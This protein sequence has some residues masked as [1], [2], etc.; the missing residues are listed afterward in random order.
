MR[1]ILVSLFLCLIATPAFSQIDVDRVMRIGCNTLYFDDYVLSIRYFNQAIEAKPWLAQPY[2]YR[3]I[4][5]LNLDDYA[6][7]ELDATY[8]I[9]RNPFLYDA[10]EVR[11][12][13][14]QNSGKLK[15]A[16]ED[17]NKVLESLPESRALLFNKAMAQIDL[18]QY[19][20]ADSTFT[21][22]LRHHPS[23]DGGWIG[24]ARMRLERTDTVGA[25][26]DINKALQCNPNNA[27]AYVMRADIAINR[28]ARP[29][30]ALADMDKAIKLQPRVAGYFI[31]R[32]WLRYKADDYYGAMA[33]YDYA[34]R[35]EPTNTIALFNRS[36]LRY[37]VH[38][39]NKAVDDLTQV[40]RLEPNNHKALFNRAVLY[41]ET[42]QFREAIADLDKLIEIFPDFSAAWFLR[43]EVKN[44]MGRKDAKAD[45]NRSMALASKDVDLKAEDFFGG[46][47]ADKESEA[48]TQDQVKERF[49]TLQ[50]L[51]DA[52]APEDEVYNNPN[53]K[54]RIQD[55]RLQTSLLPPYR[56]TYYLAAT[57]MRPS[58]LWLKEIQEINDSRQ[59]PFRLLASTAESSMASDEET[60]TAHNNSVEKFSARLARG[61]SP[62]AI[63]YFGRGMDF[64][65]LRDFPAAIA[66]FTEAINIAPDFAL[67]YFARANA[68]YFD[69]MANSKQ[70][71]AD[72][73]QP[74]L[75]MITAQ[76]VADLDKAAELSP[77]MAI[78]H[79]NKGVALADL[80][81]DNT[82]A[83]AAF[84]RAIEIDP[85]LAEAWYNRGYVFLSL[86]SWNE[87]SA[88]LSR[89][90]ELGIPASYSLLKQMGR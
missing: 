89:A 52:S 42:G 33:D 88:D 27:N 28:D 49:T 87:A 47:T 30:S 14:R 58:G 3:S 74:T 82:S 11:G 24:R 76:I 5:K 83:L 61:S 40:L 79:Y 17:Y 13:A 1:S 57:E 86:G 55:R 44:L 20:G 77:S 90:G 70:P 18:K 73:Q 39:L 34:L 54:G 35:L 68:Q 25:V 84:T 32:A 80:L 31:N 19:D 36:L 37:E 53:I 45:Y 67:A 29:D 56:L 8:A 43:Y 41:R 72:V 23:F 7:A 10:Y 26:E 2:F 78:A 65:T 62:R 71:G 15:E 81:G 46:K 50:A 69:A 38:D 4:A 16:I 75:R 9:E 22:L 85:G 63:D 48:L 21:H 64:L 12:V 66:D 6:G 59:I 51:S 60:F